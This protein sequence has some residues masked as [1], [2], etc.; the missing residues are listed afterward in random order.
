MSFFNDLLKPPHVKTRNDE[1]YR[2]EDVNLPENSLLSYERNEM[3]A[4][5]YYH[6]PATLKTG[7]VGLCKEVAARV[8]ASRCRGADRV[9]D[10]RS[11][12]N[13]TELQSS[14]MAW[15]GEVSHSSILI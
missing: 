5:I 6:L 7:G 12:A 11:S 14:H 2:N 10:H 8:Q 3:I 15:A 9:E 13:H 4:V 1:P